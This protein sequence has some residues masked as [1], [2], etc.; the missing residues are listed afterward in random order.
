MWETPAPAQTSV[1]DRWAYNG[2]RTIVMENS[3]LRLVIV[4]EVGGKI[5]SLEY[6][7]RAREWLWRNPRIPLERA[8]FGASFDDHWSGGADVFFPTC[9][10]CQLDGVRVPDS[11]EWWSIP[12][13]YDTIVD[14]EGATVVLSAGGRIWPVEARRTVSLG[15]GAQH[16][17]LG[18]EIR[19]VGHAPLPFL[20]GF[21]PALSVRAGAWLHLPAGEVQVDES[22]GGSMGQVG[23]RYRWPRLL[24]ADGL[25]VDMRRTRGREAG[26]YGGHFFFPDD[27][28]VWWALTD[29]VEGVGL[30][31][32]ASE[33]FRGLW[34]WQVYGGWR[35]YQ[36]LAVEPWTSHPITLADAVTAGTADWLQP[37]ESFQADLV[38]VAFEG[39][40][41]V[42]GVDAT[43]A[44]HLRS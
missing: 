11:G 3:L 15:H 41:E 25:E 6:R 38:L 30:G 21:H 9:Y 42:I 16:V 24:T 18:F 1:D 14:G 2:L 33:A 29:P 8:G 36:H 20:L 40:G 10:P 44:V 26:Q 37:G 22:S 17:R 13:H 7:P 43:G 34:L 23:Q 12:W 19:N 31:C 32:R 27:G 28:I 35:G 5:M 4:P 39:T